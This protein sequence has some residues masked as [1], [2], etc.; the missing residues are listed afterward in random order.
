[1]SNNI[2]F[3]FINAINKKRFTET[4]F[5]PLGISYLAAYV[6]KYLNKEG[7]INLV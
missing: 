3:L 4:W 6:K 1:M 5:H 7:I 2:N